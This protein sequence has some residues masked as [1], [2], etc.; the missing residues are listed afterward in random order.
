[1][2]ANSAGIENNPNLNQYIFGFNE[3]GKDIRIPLSKVN[4]LFE[5]A[6]SGITNKYKLSES[7][8]AEGSFVTDSLLFDE[9][10]EITF[11]NVDSYGT[12]MVS[13]FTLLN[14]NKRNLLIKI[15]K[16]GF[17]TRAYFKIIGISFNANTLT[18]GVSLYNNLKLGVLTLGDEVYVDA[19]LENSLLLTENQI[20]RLR[21]SVYLPIVQSI[22]VS[23]TTFEKGLATNLVFTWNVDKKDDTLN[24]C[25]VDSI[26]KLSEATGINRTYNVNG[27]VSTKTVFLFTNVTRNDVSGGGFSNSN[28]A[29]STHLVPQYRG[30]TADAEPLYT[31]VG[32]SA[33]SKILSSSNAFTFT[34][35]YVNQ[36][37]FII[38]RSN[39]LTIKDVS[40]F[41]LT[42]G[43]WVSVS[44]FFIKKE[45]TVFLFDGTTETMY[46]YRTRETINA[47]ATFKTS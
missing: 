12:S 20:D 46:I 19:E 33:Y 30:K 29:T 7:S 32:L 2:Y 28:S 14:T 25:T 23:P 6:N 13:L 41:T 40:D 36:Y 15:K 18:L 24:T 38:S 16:M 35:T 31:Y 4:N 10:T 43:D 44:A 27:Q 26:N 1:M 8:L 11:N 5:K 34:D 22:S 3:A 45:V 37:A 9:I 17:E 42:I 39:S 21:D 47:T